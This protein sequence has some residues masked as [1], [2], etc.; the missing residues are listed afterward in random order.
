MRK[1]TTTRTELCIGRDGFALPLDLVTS[2]QAILARKRSGKSYT[3]SVEAE[4]LLRLGQQIAVIDP[5]GAW[6]GIKSSADG[7]GAGYPVAV[8][9]GDHADVPLDSASGTAMAAALVE[10]GFSAIFDIRLLETRKQQQF[11]KDFCAE[12]LR[13]NRRAMHLFLDEAD[14]FAPQRPGSPQQFECLGTVTRLVSQGGIGGVGVTMI[15]QRSAKISWDVLSQV[16]ILTVLRMGAPN[17]IRPVV[18][19]LQSETTREFAAQVKAELPSLPVGTAFVASASLVLA[20]RIEVRRRTTFNSGATPKA[21]E[22]KV[23][24]KVL[25]TVDIERL[26][27]EIAVS[28]RRAQESSPEFLRKRI[29]ELEAGAPG[30]DTGS[31]RVTRLEAE[32]ARLRP[33]AERAAVLAAELERSQAKLREMQAAFQ[34]VAARFAGTSTPEP[35]VLPVVQPTLRQDRKAPKAQAG[36][37]KGL[38]SRI[39]LALAEFRSIGRT[40][41]PRSTLSAWARARGGHF[42]NTLGNLRTAGLLEYPSPGTVAL[43]EQ[44]LAA[45]PEVGRPPDAAALFE[46]CCAQVGGGLPERVLRALRRVFPDPVTRDRLSEL[47]AARGGHFTNTLGSLHTAGFIEYPARGS[48]RLASWTCRVPEQ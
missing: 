33:E 27:R 29:A 42:T 2:T 28:A 8:F 31:G 37:S 34:E 47:V 4:E 5:T 17:D 24:P 14:T 19:W 18:D 43:T 32:L 39:L 44:G 21:G 3:A 15:T 35:A 46:A 38:P 41:V 16:D 1:A 11:V 6:W 7:A 23:E 30:K 45:A 48:V 12:L 20:A 10:H 13:L 40:A 36:V 9:G 25:A 26:G 22:R